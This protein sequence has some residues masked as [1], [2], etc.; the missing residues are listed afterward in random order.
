VKISLRFQYLK[1]I[2]VQ[3]ANC[4][5]LT[6]F[7]GE[8]DEAHQGT[9]RDPQAATRGRGG[10]QRGGAQRGGSNNVQRDHCHKDMHKAAVANH[11][12]KDRALRKQGG[13]AV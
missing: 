8:G 3:V 4:S 12:R 11:H 7:A 6:L 13:P 2:G 9:S 10:G 5:K 1:Y